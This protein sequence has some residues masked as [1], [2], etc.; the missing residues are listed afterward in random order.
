MW[1]FFTFTHELVSTS[2]RKRVARA[3]HPAFLGVARTCKCKGTL[4]QHGTSCEDVMAC[5]DMQIGGPQSRAGSR[6]GP[7]D[8][9]CG[10]ANYFDLC[11]VSKAYR[12]IEQHASRR[13]RQWF[14]AH[15]VAAG[16]GSI[17]GRFGDPVQSRAD[18]AGGTGGHQQAERVPPGRPMIGQ[19]RTTARR[20]DGTGAFPGDTPTETHGVSNA[21]SAVLP[22]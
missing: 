5:V 14:V 21:P 1:L 19:P 11:Q 8:P 22:R 6:T 4:T 10:R 16:P 3:L 13:L 20:N 2:L 17:D 7:S 9:R 15:Q 12:S 18:H